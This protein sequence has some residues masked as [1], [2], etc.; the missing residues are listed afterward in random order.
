MVTG[1]LALFVVAN[2][3]ANG[4]SSLRLTYRGRELL[5]PRAAVVTGICSSIWG[6]L[7]S[8]LLTTAGTVLV[9]FRKSINILINYF[10]VE[11]ILYLKYIFSVTCLSIS[12]EPALIW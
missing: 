12:S 7:A 5:L 9:S 10:F 8:C 3:Q 1:V 6:F 11:E 2:M 4:I